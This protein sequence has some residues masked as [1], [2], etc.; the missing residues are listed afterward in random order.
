[1]LPQRKLG[2]RKI[3]G[4]NKR[5]LSSLSESMHEFLLHFP[6]LEADV[7][8]QFLVVLPNLVDMVLLW[9]PRV[10]WDCSRVALYAIEGKSPFRR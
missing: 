2:V 3:K 5:I 1:M 8:F 6:L 9:I 7:L 10:V 4:K